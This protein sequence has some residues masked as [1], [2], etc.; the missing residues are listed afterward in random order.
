MIMNEEE[1]K[2]FLPHREPFL[3]IDGVLE[4]E[5]G[6]RIVAIKRFRP[7]E[8]F[9]RGHFPGNPVV[10]GVIIVE[11]LAQ[12]GGILVYATDPEFK[13]IPALV[14]LENVKF[15]KPVLPGMEVKLNVW[16]LKR[17]AQM[18]KMRGEAFIEDTKV[19]EADILASFF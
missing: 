7:Q 18:W 4:M 1:I 16:I 5:P 15:R 9:F 2:R 11:A 10:P 3:F 13:R 17:R 8:E 19:S 6:E 14:G 12:A